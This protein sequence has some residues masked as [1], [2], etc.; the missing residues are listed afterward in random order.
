MTILSFVAV[1]AGIGL[2]SGSG[3]GSAAMLVAGV[4]AGSAAWWLLLSTGTSM[5]RTAIGPRVMTIVNQVSGTLI[6]AF[7]IY[8][9]AT[10]FRR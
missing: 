5:L 10:S 4:F 8:A 7:G 9:I 1:F 2:V 6:V 3:S